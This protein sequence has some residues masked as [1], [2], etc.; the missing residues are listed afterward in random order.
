[1][2]GEVHDGGGTVTTQGEGQRPDYLA[3]HLAL[4]LTH[5]FCALIL[6]GQLIYKT[7]T[8]QKN[9][10]PFVFWCFSPSARVPSSVL[11]TQLAF[12]QH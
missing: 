7:K 4:N 9:K 10:L 2:G 11:S 8:K 6:P 12:D 1:M 3:H 5:F